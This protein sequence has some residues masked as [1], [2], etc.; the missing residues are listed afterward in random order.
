VWSPPTRPWAIRSQRISRCW[1]EVPVASNNLRDLP[2]QGLHIILRQPEQVLVCAQLG[3]EG[4]AGT[5][6]ARLATEDMV[7]NGGRLRACT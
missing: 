2:E 3:K 4:A 5:L 6:N 1:L 7:L